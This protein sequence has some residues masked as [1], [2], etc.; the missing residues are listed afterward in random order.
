MRV[1]L[2]LSGVS[3]QTI[4]KMHFQAIL[5]TVA[6]TL[7][8]TSIAEP[9]DIGARN[10][11]ALE[12]RHTIGN[13]HPPRNTLEA[14]NTLDVLKARHTIGSTHHPEILEA[15]K[16]LEARHT[17]GSWHPP[18]ESC[19]TIGSWHDPEHTLEARHTL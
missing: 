10:P 5:L 12:A 6:V 3:K 11:E 7:T 8:S 14:R 17:I 16:T 18:L 9:I 4:I 13:W 19:H 15:R 2:P 1:T